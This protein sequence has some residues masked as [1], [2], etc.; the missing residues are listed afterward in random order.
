MDITFDTSCIPRFFHLIISSWK[1]THFT[2]LSVSIFHISYFLHIFHLF[3][4]GKCHRSVTANIRD[5]SSVRSHNY[6][7]TYIQITSFRSAYH[8]I[9]LNELPGLVVLQC[10]GDSISFLKHFFSLFGR[11]IGF[12]ISELLYMLLSYLWT[13]QWV[14]LFAWLSCLVWA[15]YSMPEADLFSWPCTSHT[16]NSSPSCWGQLLKS[17]SPSCCWGRHTL[18]VLQVG[19]MQGSCGFPMPVLAQR[20]GGLMSRLH[21]L[22]TAECSACSALALELACALPG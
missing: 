16:R 13:F 5:S 6:W 10:Y 8:H 15:P 22:F 3:Q 1:Q 17:A 12:N 7:R 2:G 21:L 19:E 9:C 11:F 4:A 18:P 14:S 20:R